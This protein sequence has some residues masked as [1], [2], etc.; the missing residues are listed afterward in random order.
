VT[1][2]DNIMKRDKPDVHKVAFTNK[3][4]EYPLVDHYKSMAGKEVQF[5]LHWEHMPVV[6][7]ILK[8]NSF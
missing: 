1:V 5:N 4:F 8:V 3:P 2:W 7:P 6:G